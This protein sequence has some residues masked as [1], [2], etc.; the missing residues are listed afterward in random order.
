M[1]ASPMHPPDSPRPRLAR[2]AGLAFSL[3]LA[4][5]AG[6]VMPPEAEARA[7]QGRL[8]AAAQQRGQS[9][10]VLRL[11]VTD[12]TQLGTEGDGCPTTERWEV[13]ATV[14]EVLKGP[15]KAGTPVVLRYERAAWRCPGPVR[16]ELPVLQTGQVLD[17]YLYCEGV[18]CVPSSGA[19]S[20]LSE[21]AF[22]AEAARRADQL[23][24]LM[25]Q[26]VPQPVPPTPPRPAPPSP[27]SSPTQAGVDAPVVPD[28]LDELREVAFLKDSQRLTPDS[29]QRLR[30]HAQVM[31]AQ[32][33][34]TARI[35]A[36]VGVR[37]SA[38]A[39]VALS[40]R[41]AEAVKAALVQLGVPAT[42]LITVAAGRVDP[43]A[44]PPTCSHGGAC[45]LLSYP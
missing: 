35:T 38:E 3:L 16:E 22:Q 8:L 40:A 27:S 23:R 43:K 2:L 7:A 13:R 10:D 6:A 39:G 33:G 45:A 37:H 30:R 25:P 4:A 20:F 5:Q 41:H 14:Q 21:G 11:S 17:A 24:R 18:R 31:Q 1:T 19:L 15:A 28:D 29:L 42:R 44:S 12:V 34:L 36:Y 26:P 32:P 9:T